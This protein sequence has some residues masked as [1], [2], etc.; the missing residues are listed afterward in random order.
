[1]N[2]GGMETMI[3]NYYRAIDRT[4]YQFD[5]LINEKNK[6]FY[7]D[8]IQSLGGKIYRNVLPKENFFKNRC[9]LKELFKKNKFDAIHCH[10]GITYYAPLKYAKKYNIP[11][12]IV[13]NHGINRNFLK[14]LK[15][16]NEIWAKKRICMLANRYIACSETVLN[17]LFTND[18]IDNKNYIFLPNSINIKNYK[19]NESFRNEI[20]EELKIKENTT[21][22]LHVGTFTTPKNH[23][24]LLDVFSKINNKNGILLLVGDGPLK[25]EIIT[26]IKQLN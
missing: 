20:R 26:K 5:F 4:K 15:A 16:Y 13:H 21:V 23:T 10:Q 8:E 17:H 6:C 14:Y 18:I 3:M 22:Y 9:E 19:Y 11:I 12:R 25:E 7:E 24:F 2:A 1:M